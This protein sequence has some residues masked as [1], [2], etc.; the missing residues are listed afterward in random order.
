MDHSHVDQSSIS[1]GLPTR[2]MSLTELSPARAHAVLLVDEQPP[3]VAVILAAQ[4]D[5]NTFSA[6][7]RGDIV[8]LPGDTRVADPAPAT[9]LAVTQ[10]ALLTS[11]E[12]LQIIDGHADN[13]DAALDRAEQRHR[14]RLEQ[15]R[16]YTIEQHRHGEI[17]RAALNDF[18][19]HACLAPYWPRHVVPLTA[20][21]QSPSR[22]SSQPVFT[23][24]PQ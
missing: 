8:V 22:P 21:G 4:N 2:L 19:K 6:F 3:C 1:D 10:Q 13:L 18:L 14:T 9:V 20:E 17:C 7:V 15:I 5:D 12:L 24:E 16:A 23:K 11:L